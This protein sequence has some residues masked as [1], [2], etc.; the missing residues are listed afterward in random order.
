MNFPTRCLSLFSLAL[1]G[2]LWAQTPDPAETV[3]S[4][5]TEAASA[6]EAA[7]VQE[8][9]RK[10]IPVDEPSDLMAASAEIENLPRTLPEGYKMIYTRCEVPGKVVALTFDDGPHPEYT[11]RLLNTLR[12]LNIKATFY[13]VGRNV[14]AYPHIVRRMAEEGHEVANHSWSHPLLTKLKDESLESQ[15]KK[16]HDAIIAACGK[17]PLSYRPP[18]GEVR[19]SQRKLIRDTFGYPAILWD[20]DPLD[21]QSPKSSKKVHD[22]ILNSARSGSIILCH[23]IHETTVNA[24]PALLGEMKARGFQFATVTQLLQLEA[25]NPP[26]VAATPAAGTEAAKDKAAPGEASAT[27]VL[28]TIPVTPF[29]EV[30]AP[31]LEPA[32]ETKP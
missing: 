2:A 1:S 4:P 25:K 15:I 9:I 8:V 24:M 11:P 26:P 28:P 6:V 13:M 22:R 10:A 31:A 18:Y 5:V 12:A 7:P 27:P 19:M 17:V 30:P 21:W 16:T 20:V 3:A 29:V 23:D 14:Q 32:P